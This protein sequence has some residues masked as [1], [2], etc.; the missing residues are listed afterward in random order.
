MFLMLDMA[1]ALPS[2]GWPLHAVVLRRR[3]DKARRDP[4]T[5]LAARDVFQ[6]KAARILATGP[7]ALVVLV[8]LDGFKALNDTHGH[9]AGD[10]VLVH[11]ARRLARYAGQSGIAGRLG[12]DEFAAVLPGTAHANTLRLLHAALTT[13]VHH[14]GATLI[15][16]ASIGGH[17]ATAHTVLADAL[18][19]ADEAMYAAKNENGGYRLNPTAPPHT[20]PAGALPRRWKRSG[21]PTAPR[22]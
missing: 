9:A 4:L 14:D 15:L 5:G 8:D 10:A 17:Q 20:P 1:A 3:L 18:A 22:P 11:V 2:A 16:G 6:A 12:G 19:R 13:P 21:A 7:G